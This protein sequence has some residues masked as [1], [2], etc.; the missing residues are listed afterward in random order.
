MIEPGLNNVRLHGSQQTHQSP[1]ACEGRVDRPNFETNNVD[2]G[3]LKGLRMDSATC[4]GNHGVMQIVPV[5]SLSQTHEHAFRP[6][7]FEP[8]DYVHDFQGFLLQDSRY[9]GQP[10]LA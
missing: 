10:N 1:H 4:Q 9:P 6:A 3:V 2:T 7:S 5:R 8:G